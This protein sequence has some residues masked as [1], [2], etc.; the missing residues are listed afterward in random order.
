MSAR[1]LAIAAS[2]EP[3][4]ISRIESGE[5][6]TPTPEV[7]KRIANAL[8]LDLAVLF[9]LRGIPID[10]PPVTLAGF[11]EQTAGFPLPEVAV[12]EADRAI[13][14]IIAKHRPV[15]ESPGESRPEMGANHFKT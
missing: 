6:L 9:A 2:V 8:E 4:G 14:A 1:Q 12:Q 15:P 3:S 7:L 13:R 10:P 5:R 11:L